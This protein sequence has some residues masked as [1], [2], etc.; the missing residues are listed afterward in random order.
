MPLIDIHHVALKTQDLDASMKFYVDLLGMRVVENVFQQSR[1]GR[2]V[3]QPLAKGGRVSHQEDPK[4]RVGL[5]RGA[6]RA[7]IA[8]RIHRVPDRRD[9]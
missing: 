5:L 1:D 6:R 4:P 2:V 7:A 3:W 9:A 8:Q